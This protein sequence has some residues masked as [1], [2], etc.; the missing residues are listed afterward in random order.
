MRFVIT[1]EWSRN[2]LLQLI[3]VI[4]VIYVIG[5]W[6]TNALLYFQ[7]MDLSYVSVTE[8][9]LGSEERFLQ[10]RSYQGMLE[11]SHFH[12]FAMGLL[13]LTLTHL[14]LFVPISPNLKAWLIIIPFFSALV[15]EGGGWLV[16][17]V[18]PGFAY[19]KIAGFLALEISLAVLVVISLWSIFRGSQEHYRQQR[20]PGGRQGTADM[21]ENVG[22]GAAGEMVE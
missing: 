11:V 6:L 3:I 15:D 7:K 20:P 12:L 22:L 5:L 10:P 19:L 21:E 1:G 2:R 4:F 17:F 18:H 16:R 14:M 9:Y 13:L 8:Y